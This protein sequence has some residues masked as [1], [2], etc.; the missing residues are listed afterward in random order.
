[1]GGRKNLHRNSV[2]CWSFVVSRY[3]NIVHLT[4]LEWKE[5]KKLINACEDRSNL[6]DK[7]FEMT[8]IPRWVPYT[9]DATSFYW[10][11]DSLRP[12]R[13]AKRIKYV[14]RFH[15]PRFLRHPSLLKAWRHSCT[16]SWRLTWERKTAISLAQMQKFFSNLQLSEHHSQIFG[17]TQKLIQGKNT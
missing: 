16:V 5:R 1:M 14:P 12:Q 8:F 10:T 4:Y 9:N 2:D 6:S 11:F 3:E 13:Q 15:V 7:R 17:F